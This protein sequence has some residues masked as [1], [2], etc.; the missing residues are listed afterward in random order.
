MRRFV[1]TV[2]IC[3]LAVGTGSVAAATPSSTQCTFDRGR[4]TCVSTTNVLREERWPVPSSGP[5]DGGS[6]PALACGLGNFQSWVFTGDTGATAVM[7]G[8][9]VE[10]TT[11][12][13]RGAPNS[14]GPI[15]ERTIDG[16]LGGIRTYR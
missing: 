2:A 12:V 14:Q 7:V 13:H 1:V 4:T 6:L 16:P 3:W 5:I 15:L 11:T 8:L 10:T 9:F